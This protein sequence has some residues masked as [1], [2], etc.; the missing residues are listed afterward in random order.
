MSSVKGA[1][2]GKRAGQQVHWQ[3]P[4]I[5]G[6]ITASTNMVPGTSR[7]HPDNS[8]DTAPIMNTPWVKLVWVK[9]TKNFLLT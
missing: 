3:H 5:P 4:E 6:T 8:P 7:Q 2:R 1:G 9:S